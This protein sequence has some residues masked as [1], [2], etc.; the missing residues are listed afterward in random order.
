MNFGSTENWAASLERTARAV[1]TLP[2]AH[3]APTWIA[4]FR[5]EAGHRRPVDRPFL[6][7]LL[8]V[9]PGG[10]E[11]TPDACEA[12]WWSLARGENLPGDLALGDGA[13]VPHLRE[14]SLEYWTEAELCA[15][16]AIGHAARREPALRARRDRAAAWIVAHLQPDNATAHPWA[17]HVFL[18]RW[19]EHRDAESRHFAE[20]LVNNT[21]VASGRPDQ[22]S[23]CVLLDC[24]RAL[25]AGADNEHERR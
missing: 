8:G 23:A 13:L 16:H 2:N 14:R 15:L 19:F 10:A 9:A 6:S 22:F 21:L 1:L 5:D 3:E 7:W 12:L 24:A 11:K 25:R 17:C 18:S 20:T 4:G